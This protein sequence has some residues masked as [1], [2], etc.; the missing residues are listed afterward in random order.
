M[1]ITVKTLFNSSSLITKLSNDSG[2]QIFYQGIEKNIDLLKKILRTN[3]LID[4]VKYD[5]PNFI[6]TFSIAVV[7]KDYVLIAADKIRSIPIYYSRND[8]VLLI[9]N[10]AENIINYSVG[11]ISWTSVTDYLISGYVHGDNTLYNNIFCLG[12]GKFLLLDRNAG[13]TSEKQYFSY[14]PDP[15]YE[16][17]KDYH[18]I[19]DEKIDAAIERTIT[20]ARGRPILVPLSGGLDSRLVLAKLKQHNYPDLFSFTYGLSGNHEAM[21]GRWVAEQ[22]DVPWKFIRSK[23]HDLRNL[24]KSP[25]R[26]S[27]ADFADGRQIVPSYAEYEPL[28]QIVHNNLF[29]SDSIIVNGQ[30]GDFLFGGH[31]PS[32]WLSECDISLA[33]KY[34]VD[35][36]CNHWFTQNLKSRKDEI[37]NILEEEIRIFCENDKNPC[38]EKIMSFYE[39]W[40]WRE[41]QPKAAISNQ[42]L[43]EHLGFDWTLPLWD[44]DLIDFWQTM[45]YEYKF[46][47]KLHIEYLKKYNY[48]NVFAYGRSP[49][50]A[51]TGHRA[52]V[53]PI[54]QTLNLVGGK[55]LKNRFYERMFY[56]TYF[57][58][59]LGFFGRNIY[60]LTYKDIRRPRVVALAARFRLDE[61]GVLG[62][63]QDFLPYI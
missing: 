3:K 34:I 47:Q 21:M 62:L 10:S 58:S 51:F 33:C 43:Y 50:F 11:D 55:K 1:N 12:A 18:R 61:L 48:R 36:H 32:S 24:Y 6:G 45:P 31:L 35:K 41:R 52:F 23:V 49:Q 37:E 60:K 53:V 25:E 27:Y 28:L 15:K 13:S 59:Q 39:N 30:S 63:P 57:Q 7:T 8:Q 4:N 46:G 5:L 20:H 19:L 2:D 16:K 29:P 56:Y 38:A 42:R 9:S 17:E 44:T 14:Q 54:A 40:E 26:H 22:L